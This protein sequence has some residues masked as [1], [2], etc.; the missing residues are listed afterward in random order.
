MP[1]LPKITP[2]YVGIVIPPN[3]A[4]LNFVVHEPGRKYQARIY[5]IAGGTIEVFSTTGEIVIPP[6]RWRDLLAQNAGQELY[7][8]VCVKKEDGTWN[9]YQAIVN[10]IAKEK[11]DPY[12]VYRC[13]T[14]SSYAGKRMR[15]CQRNIENFEEAD[16]FDTQ[17]FVGGCVH[18]HSFI[19]HRSDQILIGVRSP[20][21]PSVTLYGH[22]DRVDKIGT[23]FG[24][25]AWHPSGKI[26]AYSVND[27]RQFF[28]NVRTEIHDVVDL[29]S[30]IFYYDIKEA[31][32][33]TVPALADKKR[34]ETYPAWTPDGKVLYFC[35]AP[36][37]WTGAE[38]FP[39]E[40][41]REVKYDLMRIRYDVETDSWGTLETVL[42]ADD[43]GLSILLP[44]VSPDGRFLLFCM[45]EY[46]CFPIYQPTSDLYLMDLQTG[47]YRKAPI[48]SEYAEAWHSWSSN[49]RWIVFSSKMAGGV[50]TRILISHIDTDGQPSKPFL[51][52]QKSPLFYD[53]CYY[54]FNMPELI[55]GSVSVDTKTLVRAILGSTQIHVDSVTGATPTSGSTEIESTG[56]ARVQ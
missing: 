9:R 53:S 45:A 55:T 50:F 15:I 35:S 21:L 51:L 24:Y 29:D 38:T 7:F 47:V 33:K 16:V 11:I 30:A 13:M 46:G 1:G 4:P 41:Y 39:P 12:L 36:L 6:S 37:L 40:R 10:T 42:S 54:V 17:S 34:L 44:R 48:N 26:V 22:D 5:S 49:S 23:K 18:C 2:N 56:Q 28:H 3:I 25:T 43:T 27:V 14:P 20:S 52:P 31:R 32:I 8:D 19:D